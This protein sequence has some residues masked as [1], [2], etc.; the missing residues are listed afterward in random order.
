MLYEVITIGLNNARI[1]RMLDAPVLLICGGGIGNAIDSVHMNVALYRQEGADVRMVLRI[2]SY[3]VCY[4]K[5]L[6]FD[7]NTGNAGFFERGQGFNGAGKGAGEN[8]TGVEEVSS[9]EDEV[10]LLADGIFNDSGKDAKKILVAF[11]FTGGSTIGLAEM[12]VRSMNEAR[13]HEY[14]MDAGV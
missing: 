1:A 11:L 4:T 2:T 3:N 10:H 5:L 12:D 13:G 9:N 14:P 7:G 8:L 6:R